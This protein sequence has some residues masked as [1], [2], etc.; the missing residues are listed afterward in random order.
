[1]AN[2]AT[3][4]SE[5]TGSPPAIDYGDVMACFDTPRQLP[6]L[7]QLATEFAICDHWYSSLP[8][9]TWPNRFFVHGASSSYLED[10]PTKEE[11]VWWE[12]DG[13]RYANGSIYDSLKKKHLRYRFYND[14]TGWP[15]ERSLYSDV[16]QLGSR[17]GAIPQVR[18]SGT[19][20][21]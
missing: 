5:G 13:F 11:I 21:R 17:F 19:S 9:P 20:I 14:T 15:H 4:T 7:Y 18:C 1:V 16:P 2:Y 8:G 10:S 6:V 12:V 3:S